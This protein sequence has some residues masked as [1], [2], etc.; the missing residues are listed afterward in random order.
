[1]MDI[2]HLSMLTWAGKLGKSP[3][4]FG[5]FTYNEMNRGVFQGMADGKSVLPVRGRGRSLPAGKGCGTE[6]CG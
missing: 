4:V 3:R 5:G 6:S 2:E 1:M